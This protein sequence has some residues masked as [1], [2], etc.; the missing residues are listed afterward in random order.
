M[1]RIEQNLPK[2]PTLVP[3]RGQDP[4]P[5]G[6]DMSENSPRREAGYGIPDVRIVLSKS[7][8]PRFMVCF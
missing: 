2:M 8:P 4:R 1:P 5:T 6:R 3:D 7:T